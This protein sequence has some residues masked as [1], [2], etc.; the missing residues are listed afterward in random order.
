M[1][2]LA[3]PFPFAHRGRV[4]GGAVGCEEFQEQMPVFEGRCSWLRQNAG[5]IRLEALPNQAGPIQP[6]C[7]QTAE[8]PHA[9]SKHPNA[10]PVACRPSSFKPPIQHSPP[11]DTPHDTTPQ[12]V[13]SFENS[14]CEHDPSPGRAHLQHVGEADGRCGASSGKAADGGFP[15]RVSSPSTPT[16]GETHLDVAGLGR[17]GGCVRLALAT[18]TDWRSLFGFLF[19][20]VLSGSAVYTY[21]VQEFKL[22]NDMLSEDIYVRPTPP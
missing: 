2:S 13:R 16:T 12:H 4:F 8:A 11:N 3:P 18:D 5:K 19:G 14:L 10:H 1:L 9:L 7:N 17:M 21:L 20:C 6:A 22:S 15:R